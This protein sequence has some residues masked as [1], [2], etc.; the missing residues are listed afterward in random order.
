MKNCKCK[1]CM[2]RL[3]ERKSTY[4]YSFFTTAYL[5][6]ALILVILWGLCIGCYI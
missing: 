2:K 6:K 1:L 4:K 5:L 3:V